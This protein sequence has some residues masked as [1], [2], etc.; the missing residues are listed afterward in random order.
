MNGSHYPQLV[1]VAY[2]DRA[3]IVRERLR[4]YVRFNFSSQEL[5]DELSQTV[6]TAHEER[7]KDKMKFL[8]SF[9]SLNTPKLLSHGILAT[10]TVKDTHPDLLVRPNPKLLQLASH[11]CLT[12]NSKANLSHKIL[13][14]LDDPV[15]EVILTLP[16]DANTGIDCRYLFLQ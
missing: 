8:G 11:Y 13:G 9:L 12:G 6:H 10:M 2:S 4:L 1:G 16:T 7:E 14:N 15:V 3:T 5:G